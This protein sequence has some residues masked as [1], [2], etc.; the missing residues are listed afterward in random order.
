V[1]WIA[2]EFDDSTVYDLF[3]TPWTSQW[4]VSRMVAMVRDPATVFIYW[5]VDESRRSL[6]S[7]HFQT[8]WDQLPL[9]LVVR[10]ADNMVPIQQEAVPADASKW[11]IHNLPNDR[12]LVIDL[13]TTTLRG[14]WFTILRSSIGKTPPGRNREDGLDVGNAVIFG[15]LHDVVSEC[16]STK[17]DEWA[18]F[19]TR[20]RNHDQPY[21][22]E[23][24]GYSV[25][26][27]TGDSQ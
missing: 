14:H 20:N 7:R 24:D 8:T 25:I 11:Y 21:P 18:M 27:E 10:E 26:E 5:E 3:D 13:A 23:F 12:R 4:N 17:L 15:R 9:Y 16:H 22:Q 2:Y 1:V 19:N 6:L